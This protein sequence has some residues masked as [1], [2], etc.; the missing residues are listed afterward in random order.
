MNKKHSS[1]YYIIIVILL[2]LLSRLLGLGRH[3]FIASTFGANSETDVY[4]T[5]ITLTTGLFLGLGS[6]VAVNLIPIVVKNK[7][8]DNSPLFKILLSMIGLIAGVSIAY[9]FISPLVVTLYANN[10]NALKIELAIKLIKILIPSISFVVMTYFFIAVLQGNELFILPAFSSI[11]F[12]ILFFLYLIFYNDEATVVGLV[13]VT[14]LGWALQFI[15]VFSKGASFIKLTKSDF[16]LRDYYLPLIPIIIVTLTHQINLLIDNQRAFLFGDGGASAINYGNIVFKAIVTTIV[17]GISAVMFPKFSAKLL[18]ENRAGLNDSVVKV[19]RSISIFLIPMTIGL[20]LIGDNFIRVL[21]VRGSFD[22]E[23]SIMTANA[24]A[25]YS[26][27]ML[28]FGF[29]EVLNKAF[30]SLQNRR[31]P[32][33]ITIVVTCLN[34]I[35]SFTVVKVAGFIAIPISTAIAYFVG[36]IIS[37]ALFLR[38]DK[39]GIKRLLITLIKSLVAAV[40]MGVAIY[41]L[42]SVTSMGTTLGLFIGTAVGIIVYFFA[43]TLLKEEIVL[44]ASKNIVEYIQ[45]KYSRIVRR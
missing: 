40:I 11:P 36:A 24:F 23:N 22:V 35:I 44:M 2:M 10:F 45:E 38:N 18:E 14:T 32:L 13:I 26:S 34:V 28:A 33:M 1:I 42:G 17:Y 31:V 29:I 9:Y 4:F 30:Y 6:A 39:E 43:I 21:L 37:A 16:K 7:D 19:L 3:T 8:N 12:N 5:A 25:F 20:I 41:G 27:F 15:V